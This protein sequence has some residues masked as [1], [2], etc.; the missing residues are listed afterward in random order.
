[1][2]IV[3][4]GIILFKVKSVVILVGKEIS[5]VGNAIWV[6]HMKSKN[7]MKDSIASFRWVTI[8][9]GSKNLLN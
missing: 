9:S 1:M 7:P 6:G 5:F 3:V 4:Q 8:K 2:S